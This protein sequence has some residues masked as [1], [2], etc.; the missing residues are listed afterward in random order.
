MSIQKGQVLQYKQ[1]SILTPYILTYTS[2]SLPQ[3]THPKRSDTLLSPIREKNRIQ[4]GRSVDIAE[5]DVDTISREGM[6]NLALAAERV[7]E[8]LG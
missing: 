8:T 7:T 6:I 4:S 1:P 2:K 5:K 3:Q